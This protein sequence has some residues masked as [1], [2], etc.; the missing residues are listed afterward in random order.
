MARFDILGFQYPDNAGDPLISG[1]IF[2]FESGTTTPKDTFADVN[3]A[4]KNT[5]PIILSAAGRPPNIFFN[6]SARMVLTDSAGGQIDVN[7]PVGGEIEEGVF[8]PWNVLTIYNTPDIVVGS[9][10]LFYIS[11]TSG[12]QGND[13]TTPDLVSWS[14]IRFLRVWNPN[15]SYSINRVVQGSDGL[16]YTSLINNNLGNDPVTDSV[17]WRSATTI[18]LDDLTQAVVSDYAFNNFG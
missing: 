3:L 1:K 8:S 7:D 14:E 9:D 6:G 11:I 10:G 16:L 18:Q 12:N 17:N 2:V 5:N 4:I 13:P 15:E